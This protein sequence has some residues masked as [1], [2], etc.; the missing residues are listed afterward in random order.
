MRRDITLQVRVT[1]PEKATWRA[2]SAG[3]GISISALIRQ[4]MARTRSW[5]ATDKQLEREKI[6]ELARLG[7]NL[8]QIA[9]WCNQYKGRAETVEVIAHLCAIE[10]LFTDAH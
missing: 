3:A 5:T 8:N 9:R 10:Q 2:K 6:R 7:N 1:A 4:A